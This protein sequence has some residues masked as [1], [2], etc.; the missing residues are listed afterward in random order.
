VDGPPGVVSSYQLERMLHPD[1]PT[2]GA[3]RGPDGRAPGEVLLATTAAETDG[4]L[5]VREV[6][7][8]ARLLRERLPAARIAVA[9]GLHRAPGLGRAAAELRAAGI[10]LLDEPIDPG[11]IAPCAGGVAVRL[12]GPGA[13]LRRADLLVLHGPVRPSEGASALAALLRLVP[14]V[15]GFLPDG[16]GGP[17][18]PT[19]TR[20]PG[21]FVAGAAAGPRSIREAIRDGAAAAGRVLSTLVPG[22]LR[23]LEPL[24]VEVAVATC[25]GCGACVAVCPFGAVARDAASGKALVDPVHCRGCGTCAAA[26][27][28]GAASARHFT[29]AQISAEISALLS[30]GAGHRRGG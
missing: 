8:L 11:T 27:P 7:K 18:E 6:L 13:A 28:T 10:A 5:A 19:A 16:G 21:V 30:A 23:P 17:F 25:S 15:R 3:V 29:S 24:A 12:E 20:V 1:G 26:C 9:G 14:D 2:G 4:E 22:A